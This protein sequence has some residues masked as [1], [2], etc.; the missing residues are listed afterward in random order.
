MS[1]EEHSTPQDDSGFHPLQPR[2]GDAHHLDVPFTDE[3]GAVG[4]TL[5]RCLGNLNPEYEDA[6]ASWNFHFSTDTP[7]AQ[8]KRV[9]RALRVCGLRVADVEAQKSYRVPRPSVFWSNVPDDLRR[10]WWRWEYAGRALA[11]LI[12]GT[13]M[14]GGVSNADYAEISHRQADALVAEMER[15]REGPA[16]G[17]KN[18]EAVSDSVISGVATNPGLRGV[19]DALLKRVGA[20]EALAADRLTQLEECRRSHSEMHDDALAAEERAAGLASELQAAGARIAE[21]EKRLTPLAPTG[22]VA[23]HVR[24]AEL[25]AALK[26]T[27]DDEG[28]G[29]PRVP[30]TAMGGLRSAIKL[31][32]ELPPDAPT[33]AGW[34]VGRAT[35]T[36]NVL[37]GR[38]ERTANRLRAQAAALAA[39]KE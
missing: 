30:A 33:D 12:S 20:A 31:A 11:G 26:E 18:H 27:A 19:F 14:E 10:E 1:D 15:G 35:S 22:I 23:A 5:A 17:W 32:G 16:E 8:W 7:T 36:I 6:A 13:A 9:A 4:C 29:W 39:G 2:R 34:T 3:D 38:I 24:I 28:R 25:E 37:R 21:L